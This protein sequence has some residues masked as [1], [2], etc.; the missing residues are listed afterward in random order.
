MTEHL[1]DDE[2]EELLSEDGVEIGVGGQP[3]KAR[4]LLCFPRGVCGR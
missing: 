1:G 4:D 3:P 2:G